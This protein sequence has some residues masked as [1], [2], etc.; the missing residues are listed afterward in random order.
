MNDINA[1]RISTEVIKVIIQEIQE[2]FRQRE[3]LMITRGKVHDYLEMPIDLSV[4]GMV[5]IR[6]A[7]YTISML[8]MYQIKR[9]KI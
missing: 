6:V 3:S 2:K 8:D 7:D 4:K 9:R 1:S 5:V